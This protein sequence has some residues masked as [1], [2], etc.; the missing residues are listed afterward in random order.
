[1]VLDLVGPATSCDSPAAVIARVYGSHV[2]EGRSLPH[3]TVTITDVH[4]LHR[5]TSRY[6]EMHY[7][8]EKIWG[9]K[10]LHVCFFVACDHLS[11]CCFF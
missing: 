11:H 5:T 2:H 10:L 9:V 7:F 3:A 4:G 8:A 6:M 1:M